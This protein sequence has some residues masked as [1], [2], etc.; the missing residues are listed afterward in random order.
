MSEYLFVYGTLL[1]GAAPAAMNALLHRLRRVGPAIVP[2]HLYDLGNYPGIKIDPSADAI[3]RGEQVAVTTAASWLRL[4]TYEGYD[5]AKPERALFRR[6]RTRVT[7]TDT[8]GEGDAWIYVYNRD[9]GD[10]PVIPSGCWLTH[11]RDND[12]NLEAV[13]V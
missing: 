12:L 6:E 2:G 10:A 5:R 1:P 8:G 3:E 9:L 4:D 7:R 13:P 11:L